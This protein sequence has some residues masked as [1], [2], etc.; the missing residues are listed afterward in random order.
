MQN[1]MLQFLLIALGVLVLVIIL[2]KLVMKNFE[3]ITITPEP[4]KVEEST[5]PDSPFDEEEEE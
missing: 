2:N 5:L 4:S 3:P 1:K